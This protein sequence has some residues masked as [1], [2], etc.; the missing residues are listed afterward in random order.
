MAAEPVRDGLQSL[1]E[2][3]D[4]FGP[5]ADLEQCLTF[6]LEKNPQALVLVLR[7]SHP[8]R[9][10]EGHVLLLDDREMGLDLARVL[11]QKFDP[12]PS[13]DLRMAE[14]LERIEEMIQKYMRQPA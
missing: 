1:D 5:A 13:P 2:L 3:L 12:H 4:A 11:L 7:S 14:A 10:T 9:G 8:E 6:S